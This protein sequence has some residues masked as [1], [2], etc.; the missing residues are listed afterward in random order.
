MSHIIQPRKLKKIKTLKVCLCTIGKNENEYAIE[1]I[2]YYKNYSIDKIFIYDNNDIEGE[3]FE[4]IL[5]NYIKDKFV[6]II[7]YR[8]KNKIQLK[9]MNDCYQKNFQKFDWLLFYDMDEFIH[10]KGFNNIK[11]F[12]SKR[13]F[14]KCNII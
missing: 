6:E 1:F 2:N 8:G 9:Y 3:R 10:L 5:N 7:N 12:L 4:S 13:N 14:G 11:L